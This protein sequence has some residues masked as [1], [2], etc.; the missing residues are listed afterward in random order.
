MASKKFYMVHWHKA[1]RAGLH[2]DLRLEYDGVLKSWA[3]PKGMPVHGGRH[4]A[5]KVTDHSLSYG[6][7]EGT[8]KSGYGAGEVKIDTSG[9]YETLE[10]TK[11]SWKFKILSGKYKGTW[12]LT[13]WKE[14]KWLISKSGGGYSQSYSAETEGEP[15]CADCGGLL[16]YHTES[17]LTCEKCDYVSCDYCGNKWL[18]IYEHD[19]SDWARVSLDGSGFEDDDYLIPNGMG[20]VCR[21]SCYG[22]VVEQYDGFGKC[23][24]CGMNHPAQPNYL[25]IDNKEWCEKYN[26]LGDWTN[27][28]EGILCTTHIEGRDRG[29]RSCYEKP[30]LKRGGCVE[31]GKKY[32]YNCWKLGNWE[33]GI[34]EMCYRG[35]EAES[36]VGRAEDNTQIAAQFNNSQ[37]SHKCRGCGTVLREDEMYSPDSPDDP[38]AL[39]VCRECYM[40][41]FAAESE[42]DEIPED[43]QKWLDENNMVA[44]P[45]E[46]IVENF[47]NANAMY[48]DLFEQI[49]RQEQQAIIQAQQ[50]KI[51]AEPVL[52]DTRTLRDRGFPNPHLRT[53]RWR[54]PEYDWPA[55][56]KDLEY[57]SYSFAGSGKTYE[58]IEFR[59]GIFDEWG[60]NIGFET[61]YAPIR[62]RHSLYP[63]PR[64]KC[65]RIDCE[66]SIR[67]GDLITWQGKGTQ[68][69]LS[70]WPR[71][72]Q[73]IVSEV[74][75]RR[76]KPLM[77]AEEFWAETALIDEVF[78]NDCLWGGEVTEL[79][80]AR[81]KYGPYDG[82]P[83]CKSDNLQGTGPH[84]TKYAENITEKQFRDYARKNPKVANAVDTDDVKFLT[85][86]VLLGAVGGILIGTLSTVFGNIWSEFWLD[87]HRKNGGEYQKGGES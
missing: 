7:W 76:H 37:M 12:R 38:D 48:E 49:N 26:D 34:C 57:R 31:C 44:V 32:C 72:V 28:T 62:V 33:Q 77:K 63:V 19:D 30:T 22:E 83:Q 10:K 56:P 66:K 75:S 86:G 84:S 82:C 13:Y 53:Q 87:L 16:G 25:Q 46:E 20:D 52:I 40:G 50:D 23:L 4:L 1:K 69:H 27:P 78:C 74:L 41:H 5:I 64:G 59:M 17:E 71:G 79:I 39:I 43:V 68:R 51:D 6:K 9:Q 15:T 21:T 65:A 8:I 2:W 73:A 60:Q 18:Y 54:T 61:A 58:D 85:K 81:D 29:V 47:E 14:D 67:K 42:E 24:T 35:S 55:K 11:K 70:C 3:I 80:S 45:D 36:F